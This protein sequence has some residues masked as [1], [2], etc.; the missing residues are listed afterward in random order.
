MTVTTQK[1]PMCAEQIPA[2]SVLCPYCGTRF[3]KDGQVTPLPAK[4]SLAG[5]WIAGALVLVILCG[6]IGT[7]LW[8]QRANLQVISNLLATLTLTATPT[9]PPTFTPTLPPTL[10]PTITLTSTPQPTRT[11]TP[12]TIP[13]LT[14]NIVALI[15]GI[16]QL[17][18][19]GD[20]LH[21]Y[22]VEAFVP[23]AIYINGQ[24]W[25]PTWPNEVLGNR[26]CLC[27][28]S[29]YIGI[30]TLARINQ[31]VSINIIRGRSSVKII[32]QP[33]AINDYTLI[34]EFNDSKPS[35]AGYEIS[36]GYLTP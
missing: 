18:I 25:G 3:G 4:K 20:S 7:A 15:D 32:Q 11:S 17:I 30:P 9:L 22:H 8:T 35:G 1:C 26:D 6:V 10:T 34:I 31:T 5:L 23:C 36:I 19:K 27:N 12:T 16:S 14:L 2:D 29:S 13:P 24:S 28:S 21:W 33:N